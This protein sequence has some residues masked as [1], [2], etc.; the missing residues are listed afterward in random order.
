MKN[1]SMVSG[2]PAPPASVADI[3][4]ILWKVIDRPKCV[5]RF[6]GNLVDD[7]PHILLENYGIADARSPQN[8]PALVELLSILRTEDHSNLPQKLADAGVD[9]ERF[10]PIADSSIIAANKRVFE[11]W[12]M[13]TADRNIDAVV[14]L[15]RDLGIGKYN[16]KAERHATEWP[17]QS[18]RD[19]MRGVTS[20]RPTLLERLLKRAYW[21]LWI[22]WWMTR[23]HLQAGIPSLS[24]GP[25]WVTE[26]RFFREVLGLDQ[27]IGL[28]LFSDDAGLVVSGDMHA[29]PFP[30]Q[31]FQLVFIKNTIDKSYDVRRLVGELV[32]VLRPG[33]ILIVDQIAGYGDCSPLTRTDIQSAEN[34]VRLIAVKCRRKPEILVK[35]DIVLTNTKNDRAKINSRVAVRI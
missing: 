23:G 11:H 26:I 10:R 14:T 16:Q 22:G 29:M 2:T 15:Q 13:E 5:L 4:A 25:R 9:K 33:G 20:A 7:L 6:D 3:E 24:V 34:L 32:R 28:D 12:S 8:C 30:D 35:K 17:G 18:L 31:N 21:E 27:H 1:T 19:Y